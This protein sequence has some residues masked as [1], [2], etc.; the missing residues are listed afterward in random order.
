MASGKGEIKG[1]V[2]RHGVHIPIYDNY[3]VRGGVEPKAKGSKFKK[4]KRPEA[5][6]KDIRETELDS[7]KKVY[8]AA[9]S[10]EQGKKQGVKDL[11][12]SFDT[13][14]EARAFLAKENG[15]TEDAFPKK[16]QTS[17]DKAAKG[18][19]KKEVFKKAT[20]EVEST[21]EGQ[22]R[23]ETVNAIHEKDEK[24]AKG[25]KEVDK[26]DNKPKNFKEGLKQHEGIQ[27]IA[28]DQNEKVWNGGATNQ[29]LYDA[30]DKFAESKNFNKDK[31]RDAAFS[32]FNEKWVATQKEREAHK[33]QAGST[34]SAEAHKQATDYLKSNLKAALPTSAS[35]LKQAYATA[36]GEEKSAI[37]A[38]LR[39]K[40]YTYIGGKWV[41]A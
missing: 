31:V 30:A 35:G 37:K 20:K 25:I 22:K 40:G 19:A 21:P 12:K 23:K 18:D 24:L 15:D 17:D 29:E 39:K 38:E 13:K 3:S 36:T 27:K 10:S 9:H 26:D 34:I 8:F 6:D 5:F 11:D 1:W 33:G 2:T 32:A 28:N 14:E 41:K 7:G 4:K 16:E